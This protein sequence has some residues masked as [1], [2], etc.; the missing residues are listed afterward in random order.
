VTLKILLGESENSEISEDVKSEIPLGESENSEI[1]EDVKSEI[2]PFLI[3]L[4][5]IHCWIF[6][7]EVAELYNKKT[8]IEKDDE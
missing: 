5:Q 2:P 6:L 3:L 7:S 1:S 4:D 8:M